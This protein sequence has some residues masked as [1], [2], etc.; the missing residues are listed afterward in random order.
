[1]GAI[2]TVTAALGMIC[3]VAAVRTN[4]AVMMAVVPASPAKPTTWEAIKAA[5]PLCCM[6][7]PSGSMPAMRNTA[8]HSI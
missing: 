7:M 3:E 2:R 6:A 4:S 1:M 5:V 8:R